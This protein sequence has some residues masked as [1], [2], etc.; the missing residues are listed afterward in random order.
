M[1]RSSLVFQ[2]GVLYAIP[3][4]IQNNQNVP[5]LPY[6]TVKIQLN[7]STISSLLASNL[8]NIDFEDGNGNVLLSWRESGTSNTG[9][10]AAWWINLQNITVPAQDSVTIYMCI[11]A[12][13]YNALNNTTTGVA[14]QLTTT[15]A[16]YDNGFT[17]FPWYENF[18]G[19]TLPSDL[20]PLGTPTVN[21]GITF[22]PATGTGVYI[23]KTTGLPNTI[24]I[25]EG[26]YSGGT[27]YSY[28]P[29]AFAIQK[30]TGTGAP[31]AVINSGYETVVLGVGNTA[32]N[33]VRVANGTPTT[34]ASTTGSSGATQ[35]QTTMWPFTGYEVGKDSNGPVS[36][37]ASDTGVLISSITYPLFGCYGN[38]GAASVTFTWTRGRY[39]PPNG[40]DPTVAASQILINIQ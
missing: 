33:L 20:I 8:Q 23:Y 7:Q 6:L 16:Q 39:Y 40:V 24:S 37:V 1:I 19:T 30:P 25:I 9:S 21:N 5:T 26:Y 32:F 27:T 15:Y 35:I 31:Q 13:S 28:I 36:I 3:L 29:V 22:A 12:T 4:V 18:A 10:D 34:L 14:P 11:Y 38:G 2:P 17:V